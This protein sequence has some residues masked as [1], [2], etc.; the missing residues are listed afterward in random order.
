MYSFVETKPC[1]S[2]YPMS[3]QVWRANLV[4]EIQRKL[5]HKSVTNL[6][7]R[8]TLWA[9]GFKVNNS[10][11]KFR[12]NV[13]VSRVQNLLARCTPWALGFG[14]HNFNLKL[15]ENV[16]VNRVHYLLAR[17]TTWAHGFR[18]LKCKLKSSSKTGECTWKVF[19]TFFCGVTFFSFSSFSANLLALL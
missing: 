15:R 12:E 13:P 16:P 17:C 18:V 5:T 10:I 7:A 4:S 6:L 8:C 1:S 9:L 14:M 11:L 2:M 19:E 3:T